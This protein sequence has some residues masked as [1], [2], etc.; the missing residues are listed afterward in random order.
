MKSLGRA[1]QLV[2]GFHH[3]TLIERWESFEQMALGRE[4]I[5]AGRTPDQIIIPRAG[6]ISVGLREVPKTLET[7]GLSF[8]D[9]AMEKKSFA[10]PVYVSAYSDGSLLEFLVVPG[11]RGSRSPTPLG[12]LW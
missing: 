6:F 4:A 9:D 5:N 2:I 12:G 3:L 1:E 11:N 10:C 7:P 8:I